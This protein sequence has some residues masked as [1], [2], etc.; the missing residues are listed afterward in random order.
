M[1]IVS[2]KRRIVAMTIA[3]ITIFLIISILVPTSAIKG[4]NKDI[5]YGYGYTWD[6]S[7]IEVTGLCDDL[8]AVFTIT[9]TGDPGEGDMNGPSQ[10]R[11]YRNGEL[12]DTVDFQLNGGENLEVT[13]NAE[14][15]TIRLEADQ[16]PGH[17][18]NSHPK[19]TIENCGCR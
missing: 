1:I 18:G 14:C 4:G 2:I 16:R 13:V 3:L 8:N 12:E 10:Y 7:S 9:N 5:G 15:D 6:K 11:V 17:L 19:E